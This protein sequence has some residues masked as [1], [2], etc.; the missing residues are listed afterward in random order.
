MCVGVCVSLPAC[1]LL[2]KNLTRN[3]MALCIAFVKKKKEKRLCDFGMSA[4]MLHNS[5]WVCVYVHALL[6][7]CVCAAFQVFIVDECVMSFTALCPRLTVHLLRSGG[8]RCCHSAREGGG[9]VD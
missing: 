1:L 3:F 2:G 7:V 9:G 5:V 4:H 6:S 8:R